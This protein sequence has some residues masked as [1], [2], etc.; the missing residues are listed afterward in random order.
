MCPYTNSFNVKGHS[1]S[2]RATCKY[3]AR[4]SQKTKELSLF[5][6][7]LSLGLN[8]NHYLNNAGL[9][10]TYIGTRTMFII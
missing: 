9:A 5:Q 4:D 6:F 8:V 2:M 3:S 1:L 10:L 7:V